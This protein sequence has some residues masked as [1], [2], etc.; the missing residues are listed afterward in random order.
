MDLNQLHIIQKQQKHCNQRRHKQR[1]LIIRH[2]LHRH[3]DDIS[4]RERLVNHMLPLLHICIDGG[5]R[6]RG[7]DW[8]RV[9]HVQVS[10]TELR[11]VLAL[12]DL[13]GAGEDGADRAGGKVAAAVGVVVAVEGA[14]SGTAADAAADGAGG[15]G[16][17][18]GAVEGVDGV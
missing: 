14:A 10:A 5:A 1:A 17:H 2:P 18:A 8:W 15:A 9:T 16:V 3:R 6:G 11:D 12:V 13:C 4:R 7:R